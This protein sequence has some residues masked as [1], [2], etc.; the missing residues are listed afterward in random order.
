[1]VDVLVLAG[2]DTR[3]NQV[4][5]AGIEPLG[6]KAQLPVILQPLGNGIGQGAG[7]QLQA[8]SLTRSAM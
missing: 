1:M 6:V 4:P 8:P 5:C 3:L 2:D 7:A